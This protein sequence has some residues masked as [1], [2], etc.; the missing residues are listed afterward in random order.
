[1]M[2]NAIF[3]SEISSPLALSLFIC[4]FPYVFSWKNA[5][6]M[7]S[8]NFNDKIWANTAKFKIQRVKDP[9]SKF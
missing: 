3:L 7:D 8:P 5:K 1:M 6:K 9:R 2:K 4:L